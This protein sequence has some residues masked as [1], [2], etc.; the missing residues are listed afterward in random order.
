M[1]HADAKQA[2]QEL[3]LRGH[4]VQTGFRRTSVE[5]FALSTIAQNHPP[6]AA[7][8]LQV[9]RYGGH[10]FEGVVAKSIPKS[11]EIIVQP[12]MI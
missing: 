5:T 4:E 11:C 8:T 12:Y 1:L 9:L 7:V 6:N 10:P 2:V 3:L